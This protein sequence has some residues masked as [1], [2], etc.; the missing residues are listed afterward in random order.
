M[1]CCA[2]S[3]KATRERRWESR[4]HVLESTHGGKRAEEGAG[5]RSSPKAWRD[6]VH[7]EQPSAGA[8]QAEAAWCSGVGTSS[9][10]R[11]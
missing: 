1:T 10:T 8:Q 7:S 11:D 2:K 5:G 6:R 9:L 3:H 4:S